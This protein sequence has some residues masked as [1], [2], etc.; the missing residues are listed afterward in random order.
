MNGVTLAIIACVWSTSSI[1]REVELLDFTG[2][3][4]GFDETLDK[5]ADPSLDDR[6]SGQTLSDSL[7]QDWNDLTASSATQSDL[8]LIRPMAELPLWMKTGVPLYRLR[9]QLLT[10][11]SGA[12]PRAY[13]PRRDLHPSVEERRSALYPLVARIACEIGV[14]PAL[15]DALIVQE[16]RYNGRALSSKGAV[17]LTQ[18][19]PSTARQLGVANAWNVHDNIRGGARYLRQQLDEFGRVDLALAAYNA[20]PGRVRRTRRIPAIRETQGYVATIM[21]AI[22]LDR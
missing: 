15:L 7:R 6:A 16:S 14:P 1:A 22:A 11:P 18:L 2:L 20:G 21:S 17:G 4:S 10:L 5:E 3:S 8:V 9:F 12:C 19:M 13:R